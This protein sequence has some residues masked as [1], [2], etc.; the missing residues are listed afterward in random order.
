MCSRRYLLR[1]IF[2][3]LAIGTMETQ[4][5]SGFRA[6]GCSLRPSE[7]CGL[8]GTGALRAVF[9][10]GTR[11][12]GVLMSVSM[13]GLTTASGMAVSALLAESGAAEASL[14]TAPWRILEACA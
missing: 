5:T 13:V 8:R 10:D 9:M 3:L 7:C 1:A 2:G 11:A 12:I 6:C 14:I 4:G